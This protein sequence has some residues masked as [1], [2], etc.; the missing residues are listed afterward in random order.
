MRVPASWL[1]LALPAALL[2]AVLVSGDE[3]ARPR[4]VPLEPAP[5]VDPHDTLAAPPD[6]AGPP[7]DLPPPGTSP[8][9]FA[10]KFKD[11]V[12][13][14]PVMAMFVMPGETVPLEAVLTDTMARYSAE[15]G[16]GH[17]EREGAARWRWTAPRS[18]GVSAIVVRDSSSGETIA[19]NAFVMVPRP[20]G[21]TIQGFHVGRYE[22]RWMATAG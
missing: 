13:P 14:Y 20:A 17:L 6:T 1:K 12:S 21:P 2:T 15:A 4:D 19:L 10:V 7:P 8:T 9:S 11:E 16:A 18:K 3:D 22:A 5:A